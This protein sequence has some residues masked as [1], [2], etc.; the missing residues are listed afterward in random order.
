MFKLSVRLLGLALVTG[1][2]LLAFM[3]QVNAPRQPLDEF[4]ASSR[5]RCAL[6]TLEDTGHNHPPLV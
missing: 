1:A 4:L 5:P 6:L 2:G 3:R